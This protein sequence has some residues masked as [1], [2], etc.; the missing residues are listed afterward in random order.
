MTK[1]RQEKADWMAWWMQFIVGFV[2]GVIIGFILSD[3]KG[4]RRLWRMHD[5][6]II[7]FTIGAGLILGAIATQKG[8]RL[9]MRRYTRFLP[10]EE[11][12][13]SQISR[14][15]SILIGITGAGMM[16]Y[17]VLTTMMG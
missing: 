12:Q 4:F 11:I 5:N 15:C 9:W 7:I 3:G 14:L 2:V 17:A 6:S 13:Q 1:P 8:D 16:M 10:P